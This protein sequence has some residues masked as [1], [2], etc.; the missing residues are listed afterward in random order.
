MSSSDSSDNGFDFAAYKPSKLSWFSAGKNSAKLKIA[1]DKAAISEAEFKL[2]IKDLP[3]PSQVLLRVLSKPPSQRSQS[4][5]N[6]LNLMLKAV[7]FFVEM[8]LDQDDLSQISRSAVYKYYD[9]GNYVCYQG[10]IGET[11]YIVLNGTVSIQRPNDRFS[12]LK[13]ELSELDGKVAK[14]RSQIRSYDRSDPDQE[15]QCM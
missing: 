15:D 6:Q 8:K 2:R 10:D 4:D 9:K 13:K 5:K 7:S 3:P 12:S 11:F 1:S 14:K